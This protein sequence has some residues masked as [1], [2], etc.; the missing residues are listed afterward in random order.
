MSD[1]SQ[2]PGWWQ[3]SDG[4]WYPPQP[5]VAR[6]A[7]ETNGLAVASLVLGL[8]WLFWVGSILAIIFGHVSLSQ[9]KKSNGAQGGR[10]MA[11]AGLVLGY[12]SIVPWILILIVTIVGT[13]AS[14]E[15]SVISSNL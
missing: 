10:G 3:A 9:I 1:T 11:I 5:V 14:T 2:G 12:L 7:P 6:V 8:V 15:F 13:S 4:K